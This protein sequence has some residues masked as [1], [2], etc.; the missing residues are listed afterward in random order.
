MTLFEPFDLRSVS[1]RNRIFMSPMCQY[2]AIDGFAND[3]HF[4]HLASRAVGGAALVMT[5]ATAVSPDGRISYADLGLWLDDQIEPLRRIVRFI[6]DHGAVPGIQLAHAGR[7]ASTQRPWD[8]AEVLSQPG[9]SWSPIWAPSAEP[10]SDASQKPAELSLEGIARVRAQFAEAA[11]RARTAGF[12][13]AE[14]HAAHGYL[15]HEFLSPVSNHRSDEYGGTPEKR[16]RLLCE[17]V[18]SVRR[19]WGEENPLFVRV[20]ATD[21]RADGL[22]PDDTVGLARRLKELGV[23]LLDVSSGGI[24]P[25]LQIPMGPGYQTFMAE[26][27]RKEAGLAAGAVGLITGAVQA[28]HIVRSGQAD[29][30]FIG[31][32][33]LRNP[34]W[35]L[36][37]AKELGAEITWPSQYQRAR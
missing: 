30:V 7:K 35:P 26:R 10:F 24:A 29:A 34:Y 20:S 12:K 3:W 32:A 2:S 17:I 13:V 25:N 11:A 18:E 33:L 28:E 5:E 21:W 19:A 9:K 4:Q 37:A 22:T 36:Q 31:R 8:A 27:V 16:A 15:L 1:L 14:I 6:A 23:D